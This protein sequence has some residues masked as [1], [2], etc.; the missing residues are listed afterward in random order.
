MD[1]FD[2][3]ETFVRV[4]ETLS[5]TRAAAQQGIA[6]S[7]ISRRLK[8]LEARLGVQLM[9]R[10]TRRITLTDAGRSYYDRCLRILADM[11]EADS[12][13][14]D[15]PKSLA[16]TLRLTMPMSLALSQ[17]NDA[18]V[19]FMALHP[20]LVVEVDVTDRRVDLVEEAIELAIRVGTLGD[21]SLI[22][23]RIC[24]VR[25]IVCASP[26]FLEEFGIPETPE[27][28]SRIPSLCYGNSRQPATWSFTRPDGT[29]GR[30]TSQT[31]LVAT[32]GDMLRAAAIAGIGMVCEPSFIIHK[33]IA[34]GSLVGVLSDHEWFDM[35]IYAVYPPTRHLSARARAFIDFLID[36]IG[37]V[38]GWEA[39]LDGTHP[40]RNDTRHD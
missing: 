16:G 22:A 32:S 31:R 15:D 2:E 36:R 5:V 11:E 37:P 39:C 7:A 40:P 24:N 1:R 13:A 38:P 27:D 28:L 34:D 6:A 25:H 9:Q 12:L 10:T 23:R 26:A 14:S 33:Q 17:L 21:S 18:L 29:K 30:V 8:E 3:I 4:A 35:S 20:G 19:E